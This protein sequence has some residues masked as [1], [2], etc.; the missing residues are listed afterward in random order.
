[1]SDLQPITK[2]IGHPNSYTT[3]DINKPIMSYE[4]YTKN[5]EEEEDGTVDKSSDNT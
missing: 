2:I 4:E 1:M 3:G 5:K